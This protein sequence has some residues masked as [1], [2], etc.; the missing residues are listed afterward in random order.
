MLNPRCYTSTSTR[1]LIQTSN[2]SNSAMLPALVVSEA[3][4]YATTADP[5]YTFDDLK[6]VGLWPAHQY[7]KKVTSISVWYGAAKPNGIEITYMLSNTTQPSVQMHG[8]RSGTQKTFFVGIFGA[9]DNDADQP[10]LRRIGF[11]V[12]NKDTGALTQQGPFPDPTATTKNIIGF[13]SLGLVV[14]FSGT[15]AANG[16]LDTVAVYKVQSGGSPN[17]GISDF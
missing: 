6:D 7:I 11:L 13:T 4:G 10:T 1:P 9:I 17:L 16:T 2:Y 8:Q 15:T 3:V 12:Y 5:R 14:G